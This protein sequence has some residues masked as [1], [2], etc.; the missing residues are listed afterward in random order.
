MPPAAS[1]TSF[2]PMQVDAP[3][4]SNKPG[5]LP[6]PPRRQTPSHRG[7]SGRRHGGRHGRG[8]SP[9][10]KEP[11]SEALHAFTRFF[12]AE[13]QASKPL[14]FSY[15]RHWTHFRD[16]LYPEEL[17]TRKEAHAFEQRVRAEHQQEYSLRQREQRARH[18]TLD[19]RPMAHAVLSKPHLPYPKAKVAHHTPHPTPPTRTQV[20][21]TV[22]APAPTPAPA[23][24]APSPSVSDPLTN[25]DE[26]IDTLIHESE[27]MDLEAEA[28]R[29]GFTT[30]ELFGR[31]LIAG[32]V[33]IDLLMVL[34]FLDAM[35]SM[36]L[37]PPAVPA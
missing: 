23:L 12:R 28:R 14:T 4:I 35:N 33:A 19:N 21:A 7:H 5:E 6:N 15:Q 27:K 1:T 34:L 16:P 36:N 29:L 13:A 18:M 10:Q 11:N 3:V 2:E 20:T 32:L 37:Q 24:T 9:Y 8:H 30:T 17:A 31:V 25:L 26:E 22:S